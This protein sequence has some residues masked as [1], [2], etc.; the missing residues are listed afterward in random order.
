MNSFVYQLR[1]KS[2]GYL[3]GV[4]RRF[5]KDAFHSKQG[6]FYTRRALE[7]VLFGNPALQNSCIVDAF[8]LVRDASYPAHEF[9]LGK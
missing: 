4:K 5:A 8:L 6:K 7:A 3:Y 2:D 9:A 1:R